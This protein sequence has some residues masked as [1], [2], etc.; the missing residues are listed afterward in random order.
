L[1]VTL[2]QRDDLGADEVVAVLE[3]GQ[4]DGDGTLVGDD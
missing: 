3:V 1:P 4:G 2:V